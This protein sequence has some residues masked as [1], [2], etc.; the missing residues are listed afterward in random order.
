MLDPRASAIGRSIRWRSSAAPRR[1]QEPYE[2]EGTNLADQIYGLGGNDTLVGLDGD[3]VLEGGAG[4]DELFGSDG[5]D[6]RE[7]SGS[8][9]RR[10]STSLGYGLDGDA[11]G[12]QL[13]SIEGV[14]GSAYGDSLVGNDERNVLPDCP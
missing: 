9:R 13:Y 12:D 7:L 4:A 6:Y 11:E 2:L 8:A 1:R 3:D 5:F 14:I 10:A